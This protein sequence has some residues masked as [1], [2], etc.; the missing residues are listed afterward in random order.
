[1]DF[2]IGVASYVIMESLGNTI[3][4][5]EKEGKLNKKEGRKMMQDAVKKYGIAS[6]KYANAAQIQIDKIVDASPFATKKD[7]ENLTVRVNRLSK[8][9]SK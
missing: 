8:K 7:V 4:K 3:H 1:M 9:Q 5:M 2:G 6:T